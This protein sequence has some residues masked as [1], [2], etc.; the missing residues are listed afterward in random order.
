[1]GFKHL[2]WAS[3][4]SVANQC[5]DVIADVESRDL[6]I[7]A[8]VSYAPHGKDGVEHFLNVDM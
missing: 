6:D 2:Q 4:V 1:M 8:M 7:R 3:P 5:F